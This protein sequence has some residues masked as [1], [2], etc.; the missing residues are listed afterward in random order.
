[1]HVPAHAG[2]RTFFFSPSQSVC[3]TLEIISNLPLELE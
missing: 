2:A 1:M 3:Q